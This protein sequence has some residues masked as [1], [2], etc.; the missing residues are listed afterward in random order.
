MFGRDHGT[1]TQG[2][3]CLR[4]I[5]TIVIRYGI[6][7]IETEQLAI[8]IQVDGLAAPK[9]VARANVYMGAYADIPAP[10]EENTMRY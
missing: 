8:I 4:R 6:D 9:N 2:E 5:D 10:L 3:Y 7:H 1:I